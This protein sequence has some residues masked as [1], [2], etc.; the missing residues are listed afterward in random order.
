[1]GIIALVFFGLLA[2]FAGLT[3]Q[4]IGKVMEI[5]IKIFL[6]LLAIIYLA[7]TKC[8]FS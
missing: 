3:K 6:F 1:M 8:G 7:S 2:L 4:D 5:G